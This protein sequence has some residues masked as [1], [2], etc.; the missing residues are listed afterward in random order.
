MRGLLCVTVLMSGCEIV[1]WNPGP[2]PRAAPAAEAG[3]VVP[4]AGGGGEVGATEVDGQALYVQYCA[5]CHGADGTG[6]GPF[7]G[8]IL[9]WGGMYDIVVMGRG[10][11][12]PTP[13]LNR[14]DV[15]AMERFLA[16]DIALDAPPPTPDNIYAGSC[17]GCHGAEGEGTE[18]GPQMRSPVVGYAN[19]VTRT[20]RS[21]VGFDVA[22]PAYP[23]ANIAQ[24]DLDEIWRFLH[25][26]PKPTDGGGLYAQFRANCHGADARGGPARSNIAGED[27]DEWL[28]TVRE[29]EGGGNYGDRE[30]YMPAWSR[31]AISD[32]EIRL[33]RE[34]IRGL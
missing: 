18:R 17:A 21:G 1:A 12:P 23:E 20:G 16:G 6:A 13:T 25:S 34:Y 22:M 11:M 2:E 26:F 15:A 14:D 24:A 29:G 31:D 28:E 8:S 4:V 9:G 19:Y 5:V 32:S 30:E 10:E 7:P 27:L 33:M 3:G